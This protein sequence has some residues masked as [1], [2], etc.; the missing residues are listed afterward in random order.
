MRKSI[1]ATISLCSI[2]FMAAAIAAG[3][4]AA[5]TAMAASTAP[6]ANTEIATALA[7]AQMALASKE[8][9]EARHHL[10]HV[11]NCLVGPKG[12]DFDASEENPCKGMGNGAMNDVDSKSTQYKKLDEALDEAKE[13]LGKS[14]LR[15]TQN[16]ADE[17]I[18]DLQDAQKAK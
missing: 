2:G 11:I 7:H 13:G 4:P 3:A 16:E 17:A 9:A 6:N 10:H 18:E 15:N 14:S 8:L 1:L 12:R 5:G